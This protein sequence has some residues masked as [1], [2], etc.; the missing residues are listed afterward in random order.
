MVLK[1]CRDKGI[2]PIIMM[3][4][5]ED[6]PFSLSLGQTNEMR[7]ILFSL[8]WQQVA[9]LQ[10]YVFP[11]RPGK[12]LKGKMNP[13]LAKTAGAGLQL[14]AYTKNQKTRSKLLD[15]DVNEIDQFSERHD[16]LWEEVKSDYKCAVVRDAS[17]LNW[18]YIDQ[19]GQTFRR[20]EMKQGSKVVGTAV[21]MFRDT[22]PHTPYKYRRAFIVDLVTAISDLKMVLSLLEAIRIEVIKLDYDSITFEIINKDIEKALK[23]FGFLKRDPGRYFLIYSSDTDENEKKNILDADNWFVTK[24]DSDIDRPEGGIQ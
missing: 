12:M 10:V 22:G 23:Q 13:L 15:L 6:L 20:F 9:P 11:L 2:G 14:L 5:K 19:P 7:S 4:A 24:G 18:K 8:G 3:K 17:Y 21:L 16:E 1:S